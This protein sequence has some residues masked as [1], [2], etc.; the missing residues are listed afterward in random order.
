MDDIKETMLDLQ[1]F[2]KG[3]YIGGG[4]TINTLSPISD[5]KRKEYIHLIEKILNNDVILVSKDKLEKSF[6]GSPMKVDNNSFVF[7]KN[8]TLTSQVRISPYDY[9][10]YVN[11]ERFKKY[12]DDT[13]TNELV[14]YFINNLGFTK[15]DI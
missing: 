3:L 14:S 7:E 15:Y 6:K 13:L 9:G 5:E 2:L 12:L 8:Y 10:E 1:L 4:R 11:T